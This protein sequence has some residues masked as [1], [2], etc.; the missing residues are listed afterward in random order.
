MNEPGLDT[1]IGSRRR[2]RATRLPLY[3]MAVGAAL[4]A[5]V[6]SA[7]PGR[8]HGDPAAS[9][10]AGCSDVEVVFARGT[11]ESPGVGKVGDPFVAALRHRLPDRSIGVYAVDYP[12]SLQF[13]RAAEGVLD[14]SAHLRDLAATCPTTD[15]VVGGYSQGAAVSGYL[16]SATVPAGYALTPLSPDVTGAI[17]AVV[18]FGAPS[19]DIL[20]L[21]HHDAPPIVIGPAFD[22]KTLDLCSPG[23]PVCAPGGFDRAAHSAYADNGMTEE[24]A[25]FVAD[26]LARRTR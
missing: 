7:T 6:V 13:G 20:R 5:L 26:R 17:V 9:T 24:A 11:F 16:T 8:A 15:V 19:P 4:A 3:A 21:L 22:D 12:A 18:L 1:W 25:D 10:I 2:G 23:D 14:A